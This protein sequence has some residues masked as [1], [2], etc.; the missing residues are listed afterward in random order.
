L[1]VPHV[2]Q[3]TILTGPWTIRFPANQGAPTAVTL[4]KLISWPEHA[5]S[6]IRYF[7]GTAT[8]VKDF[9]LP[10]PLF[11]GMNALRGEDR[12]VILDLGHVKNF[13]RVRVNGKELAVLWKEPFQVDISNAV[14]RGT[15]HLEVAITNLWPNRLIG[16]EQLP[17]DVE[18]NGQKLKG[19]PGWMMSGLPR[20][21]NGRLTF[22]T[23]RFYRRS[24]TLLE[25]GL[26]GPVSIRT[27]KRLVL[28]L[29]ADGRD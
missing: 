8:Y 29:P 15:N 19:W 4:P 14:R 13:A 18:W 3:S 5:N 27:A 28:P 20:P 1:T 22:T 21:D 25:S 2:E 7:S 6:G 24:S 9:D 23:W 16:D 10:A 11:S 26:L 17:S 12:V